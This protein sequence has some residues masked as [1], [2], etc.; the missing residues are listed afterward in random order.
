MTEVYFPTRNLIRLIEISPQLKFVLYRII[1][2]QDIFTIRFQPRY[3]ECDFNVYEFKDYEDI[4]EEVVKILREF[5]FGKNVKQDI[6]DN[7][8]K[9]SKLIGDNIKY[10]GA[11]H[12]FD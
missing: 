6:I 10:F 4:R 5:N 8:D 12:I 3:C 11:A 1:Q 9:N 2:T 7:L